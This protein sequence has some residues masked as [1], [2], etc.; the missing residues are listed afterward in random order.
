LKLTR[1]VR[2]GATVVVI[3]VI[4]ALL[5][6]G[7]KT[8]QHSNQSHVYVVNTI[9]GTSDIRANIDGSATL[10]GPGFD[11]GITAISIDPATYSIALNATSFDGTIEVLKPLRV[12][13]EKGRSYVLVARADRSLWA[14]LPPPATSANTAEL[15]IVNATTDVPKVDVTLNSVVSFNATSLSTPSR[16]IKIQPGSYQIAVLAYSDGY[17]PLTDPVER[18]LKSGKSYILFV[19]GNFAGSGVSTQLVER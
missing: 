13:A 3:L 6:T 14:P 15:E 17:Q 1:S 4:A 10:T 7:C 11:G 5:I 18:S 8:N 9:P 2:T 16:Q 12:S 19:F